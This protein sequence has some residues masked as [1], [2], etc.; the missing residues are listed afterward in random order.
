MLLYP[1]AQAAARAEIDRVVGHDRLPQ[2]GDQESLPYVTALVK[3]VLRYVY[4]P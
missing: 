3:E 4:P 1:E 2:L